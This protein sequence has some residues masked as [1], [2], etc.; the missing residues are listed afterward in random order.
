MARRLT[1]CHGERKKIHISDVGCI[2]SCRVR[3][4]D[5]V[6]LPE[7]ALKQGPVILPSSIDD[8]ALCLY[9]PVERKPQPADV[10]EYIL[11]NSRELDRLTRLW[12]KPEEHKFTNEYSHR[13]TFASLSQNVLNN[14]IFSIRSEL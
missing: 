13:G 7:S 6:A 10:Y 4:V 1:E 14:Y 12:I 11:S 3:N 5:E 2:G 9:I 8:C